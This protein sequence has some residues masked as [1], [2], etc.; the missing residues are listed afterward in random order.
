MITLKHFIHKL[1]SRIEISNE[2]KLVFLLYVRAVLRSFIRI[3]VRQD[4]ASV[5]RHLMAVGRSVPL[6][7]D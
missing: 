3:S 1:G 5:A 4:R 2:H 7:S 6:D